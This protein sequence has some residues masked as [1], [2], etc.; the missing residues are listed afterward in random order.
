MKCKKGDIY[1]LLLSFCFLCL[2]AW[3][4]SSLPSKGFGRY[5]L[6]AHRGGVV[7]S[8]HAESS[9]SALQNA[10]E[11]GYWMV[12][13]D[14]RLTKDSVL[15]IQ[16]DNNFR[17]YYDTD[18]AVS[19]MTWE[20]ISQLQG[21]KGNQVMRLEEA[22]ASCSGRIQVMLDNKISGNDTVLFRRVLR[23]L[24]QYG[25]DKQAM[26]I[27]TDESTEYFTGKIKLSCTRQ[28]LEVNRQKPGYHP[29]H[30]Y[31]FGDVRN[32]S[33]DDV[34]WAQYQGI[35]VVGVINSFRYRSRA[36]PLA[37]AARDI[38][39]LKSWGVQYFQIDSEFDRFFQR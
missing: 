14:L 5:F 18:K 27:G 7:D 2:P 13:L 35:R 37:V 3:G 15:I 4:Q 21:S 19:A 20:E 6:I 28:Q 1:L 16:H 8:S 26:M 24:Q 38:A 22:L 11:R 30:Y 9:L 29:D 12:E 25:L 39:R 34:K 17:R 36:R 33:E 23:L 10:V 31:L 32:M